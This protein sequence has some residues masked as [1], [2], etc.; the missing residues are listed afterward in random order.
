MLNR[1]DFLTR[2][3]QGSSLFALSSMVPGFLA[4]TAL[5]VWIHWHQQSGLPGVYAS[6]VAGQPGAEKL[7]LGESQPDIFSLN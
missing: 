1:R 3:L 4:N 7:W 5:K 2:T 6:F